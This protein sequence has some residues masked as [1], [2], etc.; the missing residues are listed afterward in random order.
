[1]N[2]LCKASRNARVQRLLAESVV[3]QAH[4]L[5]SKWT[6]HSLPVYEKGFQKTINRFFPV[7]WCSREHSQ[8]FLCWDAEFCRK[9]KAGVFHPTITQQRHLLWSETFQPASF[10]ELSSTD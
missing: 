3:L 7:L 4:T 2:W 6:R 9:V 8:L 10:R 5:L 1:M